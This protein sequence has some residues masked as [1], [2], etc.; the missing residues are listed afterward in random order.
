MTRPV[1]ERLR[2]ALRARA[3]QITEQITE[4]R[5]DAVRRPP[6]RPRRFA[7]WVPPMA[8]AAA[9]AVALAVPGVFA[10]QRLTADPQPGTP[11]STTTPPSSPAPPSPSIATNAVPE[12]PTSSSVPPSGSSE[13]TPLSEGTLLGRGPGSVTYNGMTMQLPT[14]WMMLEFTADPG[15]ACVRATTTRDRCEFTVV[16]GDSGVYYA[17]HPD[18]PAQ[19]AMQVDCQNDDGLQV[20][21]LEASTV[22]IGRRS[23]EY[24]KFRMVCLGV[25]TDFESWTLGTKPGVKFHREHIDAG[26]EELVRATIGTARF[27]IPQTS[28]VP[29]TDFGFITGYRQTS[30]GVFLTIDRATPVWRS[31]FK[32]D[33]ENVNPRTYEYPFADDGV[34]IFDREPGLCH[35]NAFNSNICDL[36]TLLRRLDEGDHR[37]D[38]GV[39]IR[40]IPVWIGT[41]NGEIVR[42]SPA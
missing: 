39:P 7:G 32:F 22:D 38:G 36:P 8:V 28:D 34:G 1:E 30:A 12:P 33:A 31:R 21:K 18:N 17:M 20:R 24:R 23:A 6:P 15:W 19:V 11:A 35:T 41:E 16:T 5:P 37:S 2:A 26:T 25:E 14:D 3:E 42:I 10:V 40:Q 13:R 9:V 29:L 27:S 4:D